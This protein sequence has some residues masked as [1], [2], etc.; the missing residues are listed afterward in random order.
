MFS[1]T[2]PGL[3]TISMRSSNDDNCGMRKVVYHC[4]QGDL[5]NASRLLP[6]IVRLT[7]ILG[8]DIKDSRNQVE[9]DAD[10]G[11]RQSADF[12]LLCW[13]IFMT[14]KE[15]FLRTGSPPAMPVED[16]SF[17]LSEKHFE[18]P[19]RA[20]NLLLPHFDR[21][22]S[23]LPLHFRLS[24]IVS[25]IYVELFAPSTLGKL[26]VEALKSVR[27][28]DDA[29]EEW[30]LSI[31]TS[32]RPTIQKLDLPTESVADFP[33]IILSFKYYHCL[34]SIYQAFSWCQMWLEG[35]SSVVKA[36][37]S[38]LTVS[39]QASRASLDLLRSTRLTPTR[40][41]FWYVKRCILSFDLQSKIHLNY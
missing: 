10:P 7:K 1:S 28:L 19:E 2:F 32:L 14:D 30:R 37:Q 17:A 31:H 35:D 33:T 23:F 8:H 40:E 38:S 3:T 29:I 16:L 6:D 41:V 25:E 4:I 5:S 36:L 24:I 26:G 12:A 18:F 20:L 22:R 27:A 9:L 11:P 13:V 39:A 34:A 21:K 15:L